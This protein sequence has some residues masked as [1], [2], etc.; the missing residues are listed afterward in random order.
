V[1]RTL[2]RGVRRAAALVRDAA[3]YAAGVPGA[4]DLRVSYGLARVPGPHRREV[5]GIVKLQALQ[6]LFPNAPRRFNVLYLVTSRLPHGAASLARAARRKGAGVVVNQNGVAYPGWFGPGWER[7]NAP[8]RTLM[9]LADHVFYQSA[10]CKESADRFVGPPPARWEILYNAVDTSVFTPVDGRPSALTLL[11]GGS[12]DLRYRLE[13]ALRVLALVARHRA[14]VRL[15][16]TGRLRWT[17][18][19]RD[20]RREAE[21]LAHELGVLERVEF[22]G[23]YSQADAPAIFQRA[24]MLLHTKYNDPCP[25]VVLEGMASGLPVVYSASGGVPE[26]VGEA[27][28]IGVSAEI[29]WE[30]D[31]PPA[32]DTMAAAVL[33]LSAPDRYRQAS[34]AARRRAIERFDVTPW[35]ER[36]RQVFQALIG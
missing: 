32:P 36:H 8:M 25:T 14:D 1:S 28:G 6:R 24:H 29:S 3:V 5:G 31:D 26:L 23:P 19:P 9:T 18:D 22:L 13:T 21:R 2:V 7:L 33:E 20:S 35:L 11:L 16:V 17:R 34:L 12:Q 27:A 4:G 30:R 15:L 10:F